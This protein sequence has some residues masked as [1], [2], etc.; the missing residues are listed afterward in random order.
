MLSIGIRLIRAYL[1]LV[2]ATAKISVSGEHIADQLQADGQGHLFVFWHNRQFILPL[3]RP[4]DTVHCLISD[5]RDGDYM[6]ALIRH[7]NKQAIR[8][9]SSRNGLISMKNIMRELHR[10][11]SVGIATDG[12]RGPAFQVKPGVVQI[13]QATGAPIIP[14]SFDASNKKV[15]DSWD[16]SY[17]LFPFGKIAIVYG[18]PIRVEAEEAVDTACERVRLG[19]LAAAE[20]ARTMLQRNA[21]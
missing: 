14:V 7:F 21:G 15:L 11:H 4:N 17:L 8:G 2:Q 16:R 10:G 12:P 19:L 20:Q 6:A 5:S 3:L 18:A 9:S 13:A 1:W